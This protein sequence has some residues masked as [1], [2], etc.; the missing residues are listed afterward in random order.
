MKKRSNSK[1]SMKTSTSIKRYIIAGLSFSII[2]AV[3]CYI[4]LHFGNTEVAKAATPTHQSKVEKKG[5][6]ENNSSWK[7]DLVPP[8]TDN[9]VID[10]TVRRNGDLNLGPNQTLTVSAGDTLIVTGDLTLSN[11]SVLTVE[12]NAALIVWENYSSGQQS[13]DII[14]GGGTLIILGKISFTNG[15]NSNLIVNSGGTIYYD[16]TLNADIAGK[17]IGTESSKQDIGQVPNSYYTFM[18]DGVLPVSL[19]GFT[20]DVLNNKIQ[21]NWETAN[22]EN[23]VSYEVQKSRTGVDFEKIGEIEALGSSLYNFIDNKAKSGRLFYRIAMVNK[24][25]TIKYSPITQL[26]F[27]SQSSVVLFPTISKGDEINFQGG[28][29]LNKS[30]KVMVY[31]LNGKQILSNNIETN[32]GDT[33]KINFDKKLNR[34]N[35]FVHFVYDDQVLKEKFV[36]SY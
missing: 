6:W 32:T 14:Q 27:S 17:I 12:Q 13:Q 35:Y 18:N 5:D 20:A 24:D 33:Y 16:K 7:N 9:F 28:D 10:G 30:V 19:L 8:S 4:V 11:T 34:G 22:E 21:L 1:L 23:V 25:Q 15:N 36:V 31:D 2:I 29:L 26:N 3:C